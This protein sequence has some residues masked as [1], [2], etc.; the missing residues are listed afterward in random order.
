MIR[1]E[2]L[3]LNADAKLR[4]LINDPALLIAP[5]APIFK[6]NFWDP[7][8]LQPNFTI[9]FD[10]YDPFYPPGILSLFTLAK[11]MGLPSPDNAKL[12][13][14]SGTGV[15]TASQQNMPGISAP[16]TANVP[17]LFSRFDTDF[18]FFVT[19]PF[20][21]R[22]SNMN[23]FS[24]DG[25]PAAP[26]DDFGRPNSY[27]L[28]RVQA[29]AKTTAL[30]GTVG[31]I[32]ASVD[33]VTPVSA[34]ATCAKCHTSSVDGGG[35]YAAD[36]TFGGSPRSGTKFTVAVAADDTS[37]NPPAVKKEWAA[38]TNVI[39]LH[40]A[41][42]GTNL[43]SATPV[44][45]QVCHYTPAEKHPAALGQPGAKVWA[46]IWDVIEPMLMQVYTRGEATRSRDLLL[47]IDRGY[48]EEAYFSFSYS[49]IY[50]DDGKIG[51]IFCPVI[52][53]TEK[54]IGERRLRTL[55]DL[56]AKCKGVE[57]EEGTFDAAA[58]ILAAN[59]HDVPFAMIYEI[60]DRD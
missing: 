11:D 20:G 38:D 14:V 30:T 47:H 2:T 46:E 12:Y 29:K 33:A 1:Q 59:P 4:T 19:F 3:L 44:S 57:S 53:T 43:Q 15:L 26:F 24:A 52:E 16:Y 23:W 21:Y 17:Q 50:D 35:G 7:S 9:A 10:C 40:D 5:T 27:P 56:A 8:P 22:L 58:S 41:K 42:H 39:R 28:M 54:V 25:I 55:R 37:T 18:P 60:D 32:V 48:L 34:E 6:T 13:P 51:G 36:V 31:A 45:C 49:P